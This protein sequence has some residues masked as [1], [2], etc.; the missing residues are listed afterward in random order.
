MNG[1]IPQNIQYL[2]NLKEFHLGRNPISG[3][4]PEIT[5]LMPNLQ[6]YS[7]DFCA[8]TGTIPDVFDNMPAI[9][10]FVFD[11]NY[12]TGTIPESLGSLK[13]L[14]TLAVNLNALSGLM[15]ED[16]CDPPY[17]DHCHIGSDTS[18]GPPYCAEFPWIIKS[19]GNKFSCPYPSCAIG[20]AV[21]NNTK[22]PL[23]PCK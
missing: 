11:G 14:T 8:L 18:Y 21:C 22:S 13:N 23:A 17:T 5:Q 15:P 10:N 16:I 12:L 7:C 2:S 1:T 19:P 6:K 3:T 9:N 20:N 4:L